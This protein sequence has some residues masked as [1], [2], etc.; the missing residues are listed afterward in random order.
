[1]KKTEN[2]KNNSKMVKNTKNLISVIF[3][4]LVSLLALSTCIGLLLSNAAIRRQA[5][6]SQSELD[7]LETEGY[8]TTARANQLIDQADAK[9]RK[10]EGDRLRDT[11]RG[12]L[13]EGDRIGAIRT[14]YPD[15]IITEYAGQYYFTPIDE[16]LPLSPL[17]EE[18]FQLLED[19]TVKYIGT[20]ESLSVTK[21]IDVSRTQGDIDFYKV[22]SEGID[23]V[24]IRVGLR[25]SVEGTILEDDYFK[26][27]IKNAQKAGLE[28]GVYFY[29][30]SIDADEA[31]EEAEYVLKQIKNYEITYPVAL[32][33]EQ[34]NSSDARTSKLTKQIYSEIADAFCERVKEEGYTPMIMG[35]IRT[36]TEFLEPVSLEKY[37]VWVSYYGFPQYYPYDY[38]MW[39]FSRNGVI[40]GIE[41]EVNLDFCVIRKE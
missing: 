5:D 18:D 28:V 13:E 24:M 3:L 40:D 41:G 26:T 21:G 38:R 11:F 6:A 27:N 4:S 8:Y 23:F 16:S 29:S 19:G 32:D 7:A 35:G 20:D 22:K 31:V 36:F 14:L 15:E 17:T 39:Q 25:G 37:P 1:M 10:E 34:T 2:T 12:K 9:A 33:L 30:Q